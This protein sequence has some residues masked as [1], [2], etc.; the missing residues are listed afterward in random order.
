[1]NLS[2]NLPPSE[3]SD[4][5]EEVRNFFDKFFNHEITFPAAQID[6]IIGFFIK[7]GFQ[8]QAAK[9]VT[10]VLL[11]QCRIDSVNPF[12]VLD[13]LKGL[14]ESQLSEVV[15]QILNLYREKTSTLGYKIQTIEDT[16]E[17]RNIAQ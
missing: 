1:M 12:V 7:R 8:E 14:N 2:T 15:T 4:S 13:T 16:F 10:I 5:A 11:T 17:S 9:S 3:T 6:A